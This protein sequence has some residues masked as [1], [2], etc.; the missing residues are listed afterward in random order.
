[1]FNRYFLTLTRYPVLLLT[2]IA[3]VCLASIAGLSKLTFSSDFRVYFSEDNQRMA[4]FELMEKRFTRQDNLIF[5]ISSEKSEVFTERGLQL[6]EDLT[7]KSWEIAHVQRVDSIQNFTNTVVDGDE[8][9]IGEFYT[10][11]ELPITPAELKE[12]ALT[13]PELLRN[14]ISADG[15]VTGLRLMLNLPKDVSAKASHEAVN[16]AQA[17][18]STFRA[19]YPEFKIELG[20]SAYINTT[21]AEV[22]DDDLMRLMP[23]CFAVMLLIMFLLVRKL[24]GIFIITLLFSSSVAVTMGLAGW[25]GFQMSPPTGAV[26][27]AILTIAIADSVHLLSMY[28]QSLARGDDKLHALRKSLLSNLVPVFVT[29]LT[30]V[31]GMLAL[32]MSE[33]QPYRDMGNLIALGTAVAWALSMT[34]IP[35]LI[36][37]MPT[38]RIKDRKGAEMRM[39]AVANWVIANYRRL[40][41]VG[42]V[43]VV[44]MIPTMMTNKVTERWHSFFE[45][46]YEVRRTTDH[47]EQTLEGL[48]TIF[49][50]ADT[51]VE[52][53]INDVAFLKQLESFSAWLKKQ[54]EVAQT[55]E[56]THTLKMLNQELN[57]GREDMFRLPESAEA[58]AQYLLLFEMSL[59]QGMGLDTVMTYNRSATRV[60]ATLR[61]LDSDEIL[62]LEARAIEWANRHAPLLNLTESTGLD[63]VFAD[64]TKRNITSMLKG[65]LLS[66]L[67]VTIVIS[68]LLRSVQLGLL[69]IVP[70]AMPLIA[71]YGVWALTKGYVDTGT[72]I[73]ASLATGIIVD[74]TVHFMSK[75]RHAYRDLRKPAADAVRYAFDSVGFALFA[76]TLILI[77][78]FM[79]MEFSNFIPSQNMA[80]L[81]SL[82][83]VMALV[84]DFLMLPALLLSVYGKK[85]HE[86][87]KRPRTAVAPQSQSQPQL[88]AQTE[89]DTTQTA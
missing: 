78:G 64:M 47:I 75:F 60:V 83:V 8:L 82:C 87:R 39:S 20:G 73:V 58:V 24:S 85:L 74:D 25:M 54:P 44:L 46:T 21:M 68:L 69:S 89:S 71:A 33:S 19:D 3:V 57:E 88:Q 77:S 61:R 38:P 22:S 80:W 56:I 65:T 4:S 28:Y 31:L 62:A 66:L 70:N 76:T 23:I 84:F 29:S 11:D 9:N 17:V 13:K 49:F 2:L 51:G 7:R 79:V 34:L 6:V 55:T 45:D 67:T 43:I 37:V 53:G 27:T 63:T 40:A 48:H 26:P 41:G 5:L 52:E 32:N 30:T 36:W 10:M 42:V 12:R 50:V 35:M 15:S 59:P 14:L 72:S 81:L 18:L 16:S 86:R 1:M